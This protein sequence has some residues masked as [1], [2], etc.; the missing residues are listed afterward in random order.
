M[1]L[2]LLVFSPYYRV[3]YGQTDTPPIGFAKSR[4]SIAKH[5]K[6]LLTDK[7]EKYYY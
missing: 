2:R 1:I 4:C 7:K 5:D 3:T 6:K